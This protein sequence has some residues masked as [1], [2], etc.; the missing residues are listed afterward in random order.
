MAIRLWTYSS[1]LSGHAHAALTVL[2]EC[3]FEARTFPLPDARLTYL[4]EPH[5][6]ILYYMIISVLRMVQESY[7]ICRPS[8][9]GSPVAHPRI[10]PLSSLS[11][12]PASS[13]PLP[14]F[15]SFPP[16]IGALFISSSSVAA[17][18][19]CVRLASSSWDNALFFSLRTCGHKRSSNRLVPTALSLG[20]YWYLYIKNCVNYH[21][22]IL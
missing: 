11:L 2:L 10:E 7:R 19:S 20:G 12:R 15:L 18:F 21:L 16:V 6:N 13:V 8:A 1:W 5:Y 22:Y 3:H 17:T 9:F 4:Y 14:V